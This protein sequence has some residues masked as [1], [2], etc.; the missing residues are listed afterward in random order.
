MTLAA[1][2]HCAKVKVM[3]QSI[4]ASAAADVKTE[5]MK[6]LKKYQFSFTVERLCFRSPAVFVQ[7]GVPRVSTR[8]ET[9]VP[10]CS[11]TSQN[12]HFGVPKV[13]TL[14]KTDAAACSDAS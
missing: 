9:D 6:L 2:N 5:A 4:I 1:T 3:F 8:F 13:S 12:F 11:E 14:L 10:V 7:F